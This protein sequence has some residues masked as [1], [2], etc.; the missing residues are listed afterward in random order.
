M[1]QK[2]TRIQPVCNKLNVIDKI[3]KF[4]KQYRL[5]AQ[6][7]IVFARHE[8]ATSECNTLSHYITTLEHDIIVN[9]NNVRSFLK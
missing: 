9:K 2:R 8:F 3:F 7:I 6:K 5:N 4:A 1:A